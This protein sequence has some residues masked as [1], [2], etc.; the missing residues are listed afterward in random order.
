M[1]SSWFCIWV[2]PQLSEPSFGGVLTAFPQASQHLG[3]LLGS[4]IFVGRT[5]RPRFRAGSFQP[6]SCDSCLLTLSGP[7]LHCPPALHGAV[8][9]RLGQRDWKLRGPP[10][11]MSCYFGGSVDLGLRLFPACLL[12]L[13]AETRVSGASPRLGSCPGEM[14]EWGSLL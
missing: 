3:G 4:S 8:Q 9:R 6:G 7:P 14:Q 2:S 10:V 1:L 12:S 11:S 13:P 5:N